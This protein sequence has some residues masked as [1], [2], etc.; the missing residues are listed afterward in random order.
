MFYKSVQLHV[1]KFMN[2]KHC[3]ISAVVVPSQPFPNMAEL[4][5][6]R[7]VAPQVQ[8]RPPTVDGP[9]PRVT[10]V[11][12]EVQQR[13]PSER[14]HDQHNSSQQADQQPADQRPA[15]TQVVEEQ[16]SED[17]AANLNEQPNNVGPTDGTQMPVQVQDS[18][19]G[20][21]LGTFGNFLN[22]A[23][24]IVVERIGQGGYA[25]VMTNV[26]IIL[27]ALL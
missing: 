13:Q 3:L 18:K 1:S 20:L 8:P 5:P 10:R 2:K 15:V 23:K 27:L 11:Q 9:A 4:N 26:C 12:Q 16:V 7:F 19:L 17:A 25:K 22:P 24:Y 6:S 21:H 14:T